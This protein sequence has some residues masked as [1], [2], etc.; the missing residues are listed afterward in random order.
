M[1]H[2]TLPIQ[3]MPHPFLVLAVAINMV[4]IKVDK[5]NESL[6]NRQSL[7]CNYLFHFSHIYTCALIVFY[8]SIYLIE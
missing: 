3:Q 7:S 2:H 6:S 5:Y 8:R 1:N 4:P